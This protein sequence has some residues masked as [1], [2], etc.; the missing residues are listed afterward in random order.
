VLVTQF[1]L[2][3]PDG[4]LPFHFTFHSY[5]DDAARTRARG[6]LPF[7]GQRR[8]LLDP[9]RQSDYLRLSFAFHGASYV[10]L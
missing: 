10:V 7:F 5:S 8:Q 2:L 4:P 6:L 9:A 3:S 1:G